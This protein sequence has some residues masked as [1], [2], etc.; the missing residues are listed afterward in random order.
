MGGR[1]AVWNAPV[2]STCSAI[3]LYDS[4][5]GKPGPKLERR[6]AAHASENRSSPRVAIKQLRCSAPKALDWNFSSLG[7]AALN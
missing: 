7:M 5:P 6:H 4:L 2:S 1:K 3:V